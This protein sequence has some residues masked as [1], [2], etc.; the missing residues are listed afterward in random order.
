[1]TVRIAE[2]RRVL[3]PTGS[4][5]LHCD[6]TVSHYVKLVCDAIFVAQ[7]GDFQNEIIWSY[8]R[9]PAVAYQFQR[10]HDV[11]LFYSKSNDK[12]RTFNVM[13]EP[14]SESYQRRFKG[15]TNILD[16]ENPT[17]KLKVDAD[18]KGLALRDVWDIPIIAGSSKE[19]LGYPTQKPEALL[20]R[21]IKASSN[22]GD[23]VL[24]AYCGCGTT[25]SVAQRLNRHWIGIDIT[26]RSISIVLRR[27][28][29]QYGKEV[30]KRITLNGIP[31][32]MESAQALAH[33]QDDR[34]RKEF[35]KWAVITY[36]NNR[37]I[38][39]D[40]KGA[41]R[42]IDGIAYFM[43][44]RKDNAKIVFQVKSG[45][46]KRSDVATLRGDMEREQAA[47]AILITLEKPTHAMIEEAKAAG[48][49][50]HEM[51]GRSYDRMQIVTVKEIIEQDKRLDVPTSLEVL[52]AARR[53]V[54]GGDQLGL[55]YSAA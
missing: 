50:E 51:M 21:I 41:D 29:Q 18:S 22:E 6:P 16:K 11:I 47:I 15:K 44:D 4:F 28:E 5:F 23:T 53:A 12:G 7:G 52:K 26:Y 37:A 30:L 24:D 42:G 13:F 46:V 32:D 27:L 35:E 55:E 34:V 1:M 43:K 36:S 25:T 40:K 17:R 19:R 39:N 2:I 49:F 9:W 38:I 14:N 48:I 8:R 31:R 54:E 3:K 20:E 45:G 10:M 33:K